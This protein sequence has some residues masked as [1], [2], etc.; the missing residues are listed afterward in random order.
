[1]SWREDDVGPDAQSCRPQA[2]LLQLMS[3]TVLADALEAQ[4][5]VDILRESEVAADLCGDVSARRLTKQIHC[6]VEEVLQTLQPSKPQVTLLMR[7]LENCGD[8]NHES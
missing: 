5:C 8:E 3:M 2:R 6:G 7:L 1:M 4:L